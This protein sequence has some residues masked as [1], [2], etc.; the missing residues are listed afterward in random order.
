MG[1]SAVW[2][3]AFMFAGQPMVSGPFVL[4]VCLSM[5]ETQ[6]RLSGYKAHCYKPYEKRQY[7]KEIK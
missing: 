5:A 6:T 1:M 2:F 3:L 7:P 4:E